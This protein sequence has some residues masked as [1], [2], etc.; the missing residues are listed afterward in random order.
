MEGDN[1]RTALGRGSCSSRARGRGDHPNTLPWVQR[2]I[3][4][5]AHNCRWQ[6]ILAS[7]TSAL[8]PVSAAQPRPRG[9]LASQ[10]ARARAHPE[11]ADHDAMMQVACGGSERQSCSQGSAL[12]HARR[13]SPMAKPESEPGTLATPSL[14]LALPIRYPRSDGAV[15]EQVAARESTMRREVPHPHR[16]AQS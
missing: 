3:N 7:P 4:A 6:R 8:Q 15:G 10:C 9:L 16:I 12:R 14:P 13:A 5:A 2:N 1:R 11:G